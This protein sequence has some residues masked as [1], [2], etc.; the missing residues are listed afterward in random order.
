M[1]ATRRERHTYK[2]NPSA[3]W[4]C[5]ICLYWG[6]YGVTPPIT[7]A[8]AAP[9]PTRWPTVR[10]SSSDII[11]SIT[12][13]SK[14]RYPSSLTLLR[15]LDVLLDELINNIFTVFWKTLTL[16]DNLTTWLKLEMSPQ[17]MYLFPSCQHVVSNECLS[18]LLLDNV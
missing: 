15:L 5:F 13:L 4:V 9:H 18:E 11:Q 14:I 17:F 3:S 1:F 12:I 6:I 16:I 10:P 8:P 2:E 7:I